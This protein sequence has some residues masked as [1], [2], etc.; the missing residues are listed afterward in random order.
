MHRAGRPSGAYGG[1]AA[2][3]QAADVTPTPLQTPPFGHG[4]FGL[5]APAGSVSHSPT[6]PAAAQVW[7]VPLHPSPQQTPSSQMLD[8]H[9]SSPV[10]GTPKACFGWQWPDASHQG[11]SSGAPVQ[12]LSLAQVVRQA[13]LL[14]AYGRQDI[15][16][17]AV[18]VPAPSHVLATTAWA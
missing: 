6:M 16:P 12:S 3:T 9:W 14:Q 10:H 8:M 7:H 17:P 1:G 15:T 18:Q 13:S 5:L 4:W 2:G 11:R